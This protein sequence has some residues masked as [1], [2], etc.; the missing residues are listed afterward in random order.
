MRFLKNKYMMKNSRKLILPFASCL[1]AISASA[2]IGENLIGYWQFE[3]NLTET[4]GKHLDGLHDGTGQG[5]SAVAYTAHPDT[6]FGQALNLDGTNG[7]SINNSANTEG[8]YAGTFDAD[9]NDAN[10]LTV[11]FWAQGAIGASWNPFLAK[12][13]EGTEGWQVRRRGGTST[14]TFTVRSTATGN[15]DPIG[16]NTAATATGWRHFLAVWD[17]AAGTRKLYI[18]GIEDTTMTIASGDTSTGGPGNAVD[19]FLT[20]GMRDAGAA[21]FGNNFIGQIDDVAIWSRALTVTEAFQLSTNPLSVVMSN[22]DTDG[23]GL[24]DAEE[25]EIGTDPNLADTD[26]DGVNDFDEVQ[27]E[28]DPLTN[29]DFDNDGLTNLQETSGSANSAYSNETTL[30]NNADSDFDGVSDGD[31]LDNSNGSVTNPNDADSDDDGFTDGAEINAG[32]DPTDDGVTGTLN[33]WQRGLT[34]YWRLDGNLT[35]SGYLGADGEMAGT[36]LTANYVAGKFG[37]AVDLDKTNNQFVEIT[38]DENY[39]DTVGSDMT[40]SIWVTVEALTTSWDG[41]FSKG[42]Q[43]WRLARRNRTNGPA[44][45]AGTV[46]DA[47]TTDAVANENPI[48]DG[49]WHHL[50]GVVEWGVGFSL[51]VDG[52]F[53]ETVEN[54]PNILD[55]PERVNLGSNPTNGKSWNGNI[56]DAAMWKRA[57]S[58][59]E[60]YTVFSYGNDVQSLITNNVEPVT[61][62]PAQVLPPLVVLSSGFVGDDFSVEVDGMVSGKSY[63]FYIGTDLTKEFSDASWFLQET[64]VSNGDPYIFTELNPLSLGDTAF[65]VIIEAPAP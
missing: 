31:E 3:D 62:I 7:V 39:F 65:Y 26:A 52:Y 53:V 4:S 15:G 54:P 64:H 21:A 32:S 46:G 9:V 34:G 55:V 20:I 41:I 38:G 5:T 61:T 42:E 13:G 1:L 47:P 19:K 16:S 63:Q 57:L 45:A 43:S 10:A 33:G 14:A 51:Y 28:S 6:N 35:D 48:N 59:E 50:V 37:Q 8:S 25:V 18:D 56:D 22:T 24:F 49:G 58:A 29:N 17:G 11:S 44:F 2:E 27:A 40:V 30:W 23:D 60:I 36:E 12:H